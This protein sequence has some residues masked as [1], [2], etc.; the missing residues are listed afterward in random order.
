MEDFTYAGLFVLLARVVR[1][2]DPTLLEGVAT[3]DPMKGAA[4]GAGRKLSLIERVMDRGGAGLLLSVGQYLHLSNETPALAV[5]L[6]S[7]TPRVLAEKFMRLER[8]HHSSHRTA[9][10]TREG[11]WVCVRSSKDR[12]ATDGEN[13]LIAGLLLGLLGAIG[14]VD[15]R[16]EIGG[17]SF[18]AGDL[19]DASLAPGVETSS[20]RIA[21]MPSN[22]SVQR[23]RPSQTRDDGAHLSERL[24][25]LVETDLGRSWKITETARRLGLSE[26]SMQRRLAA[27]GRS[28]SSVLRQARMKL[29]TTFLV[30]TDTSLAEIGY[31]CGYAD[32]AHFQLDFLLTANVTPR[33]FRLLSREADDLA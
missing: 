14:I 32:Q 19:P 7:A 4:I 22:R 13:C 29:A 10:D 30:E 15:C 16:L 26:R 2:Y 27:E 24:A 11:A 28:F 3:A 12:D 33:R 8:Y 18:A 5:L 21:W 25:A 20:F 6:R 9:I 1:N 31:C 17:Q 23:E